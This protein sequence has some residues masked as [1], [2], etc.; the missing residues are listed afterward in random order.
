MTVYVYSMYG[1]GG[2]M[3]SSA[4]KDYVCE[5]VSHIP[6]TKVADT[7]GFT[8]WRSIVEQ[9]KKQPAGSKTVIVGHSMGA[10]AA[11]YPTDEVKVDL[12]VCYDCAGQAPVG[13]AKNAGKLL[14]F[15]DRS[16][17]IV[18]KY[19]PWAYN[20][21]A[22]RISQTITYDGHTGQPS[23][24]KLLGIVVQEVKKLVK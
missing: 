8:Q 9:I 21:Y 18:P 24:P 1:L 2:R 4:I 11:T 13:I 5:T 3:W 23:D 10:S 19:R 6:G 20:G 16:W 12:I 17:A 22:N 14:D 15:W 7:L